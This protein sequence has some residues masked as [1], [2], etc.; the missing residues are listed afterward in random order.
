MK[1]QS[2]RSIEAEPLSAFDYLFEPQEAANLKIRASLMNELRE[3]I[4]ELGM[5][6][7]ETATLLGVTRP[8]VSDLLRGKIELFSIDA[9]VNMASKL[10]QRVEIRIAK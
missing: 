7:A 2:P 10:N 8:R 3:V 1:L 9:L 4:E 5:T 6:Q